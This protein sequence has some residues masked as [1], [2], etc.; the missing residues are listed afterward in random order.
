MKRPAAVPVNE[1]PETNACTGA[2]IPC[3]R[4]SPVRQSPTHCQLP[5]VIPGLLHSLCGPCLLAIFSRSVCNR[6]RR[7]PRLR[8]G[9]G[10]GGIFRGLLLLP[11]V[12]G[13][14]LIAGT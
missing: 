9:H 13:L 2:N 12:A 1:R 3:R 14:V 5:E 11:T 10:L 8:G 4:Q 6:R 7:Y